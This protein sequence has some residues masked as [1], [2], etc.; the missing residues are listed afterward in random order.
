[1]NVIIPLQTCSTRVPQKNIRKFS[2]ELSLFDIKAKQLLT[3]LEPSKIYVSSESE[4]VR[5]LCKKYGF[6][7]LKREVEY[8][9]N[10]VAQPDLIRS[11]LDKM[12]S[13]DEDI[14]WVQVTNPLFKE[15]KEVLGSWN[16]VKDEHDSLLAV[17][18]FSGHLVDERAR[19]L[20][21]S[22]GYWHSVSQNLPNWY[23]VLWSCFVLKRQTI[24]KV[25]YHVGI[26]PY[27]YVSVAKTIDIDT[28]E[29]FEV[30]RIYYEASNED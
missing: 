20:N 2:G 16:R 23:S 11:I 3:V 15:F 28:L 14:M 30:A 19:P 7:F 10:Q 1:M 27:L 26:N 4:V 29:D 13:D 25:N 24:E 22:F 12:P 9:G 21:Y 8:T 18:K 5:P 17:K 6:N